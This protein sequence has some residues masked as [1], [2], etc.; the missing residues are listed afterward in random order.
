[1][2]RAPGWP[3]VG[4]VSPLTQRQSQIAE[5][6]SLGLR[7]GEIAVQLG[8]AHAVVRDELEALYRQLDADGPRR[9]PP[10]KEEER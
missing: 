4:R 9:A 7:N 10:M 6:A 2:S 5:L 1:M 8:I 3:S